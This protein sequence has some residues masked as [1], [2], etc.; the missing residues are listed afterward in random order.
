MPLFVSLGHSSLTGPR[1][2]N[3][4]FCGVVT[5]EGVDLENKGLI[6]AIADGIGGHK[7][8]REAAE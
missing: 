2:R 7:G 3:E 6:A 4:D 5:P 8:G 1:Q